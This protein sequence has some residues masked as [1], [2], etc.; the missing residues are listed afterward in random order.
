MKLTSPYYPKWFFADGRGCE[1]VI[2]APEGHIISLEFEEF[3]VRFYTF[4]THTIPTLNKFICKIF[5]S[6]FLRFQLHITL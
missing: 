4:K 3:K 5:F 1:W 2:S 6:R